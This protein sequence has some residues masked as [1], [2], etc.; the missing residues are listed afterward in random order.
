[1]SNAK[2]FLLCLLTFWLIVPLLLFVYRYLLT[3]AH[4]YRLTDQRLRESTG[5]FS[6]KTEEVELYRVRDVGIEEPFI[7]RIFGRGRVVLQTSDLSAP[8]LVLNAIPDPLEV[9]DLLRDQVERCRVA[10]GV[11]QID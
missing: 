7:Q 9:A 5:L 4:V 11:R 1:M 3:D 2:Y 10:K 6:K 8:A